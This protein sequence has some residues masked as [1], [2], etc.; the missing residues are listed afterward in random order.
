MLFVTVRAAQFAGIDVTSLRTSGNV[1][2]LRAYDST[3]TVK[4]Q[5]LLKVDGGFEYFSGSSLFNILSS[6]NVGIGTASPG[7]KLDVFGASGADGFIRAIGGAGATKGGY[8]FG[9]NDGTKDYGKLFFD[10]SN[11]N[12]YLFQYYQAGSLIFGLKWR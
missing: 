4:G 1:G 3:G 9:N 6:G 10:N 7:Y 5:L 2:G 11:N 12:I 8:I